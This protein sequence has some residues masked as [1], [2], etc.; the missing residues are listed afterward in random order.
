[1]FTIYGSCRSGPVGDQQECQERLFPLCTCFSSRRTREPTYQC[2]YMT[3]SCYEC[4]QAPEV[5][6]NPL[7]LIVQRRTPGGRESL[8]SE[9]PFQRIGTACEALKGA[10]TKCHSAR[11]QFQ[12]MLFRRG[13]HE[14]K[15]KY[16]HAIRSSHSEI[17]KSASCPE[18]WVEPKCC[19]RPRNGR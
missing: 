2:F 16:L 17:F 3:G 10:L 8:N 4:D 1:M 18:Y 12:E 5:P 9:A 15:Q 13:L 11:L 19:F 7:W 6:P 14:E